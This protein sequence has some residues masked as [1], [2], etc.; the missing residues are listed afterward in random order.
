MEKVTFSAKKKRGERR[1]RKEWIICIIVILIVIVSNIFTQNYT[2]ESVEFMDKKLET[3]KE[4]LLK[5]EVEK[6]NAKEEMEDVM[7]DWKERY[8]KLA[9]FIEH[10]ELE[11]V[12]TELIAVKSYIETEEYENSVSELDKSIFILKHIED[13]YAFNL[14]NIF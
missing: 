8:E 13:K 11:K 6:E 1:M 9:Y 7:K 5:E 14:Q 4:T 2:K 12:E 3:L 10:D